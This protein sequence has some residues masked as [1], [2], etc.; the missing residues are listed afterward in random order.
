MESSNIDRLESGISHLLLTMDRSG[1]GILI[2]DQERTIIYANETFGRIF[3]FSPDE[4]V[5]RDV[6]EVMESELSPLFEEPESFRVRIEAVYRKARECREPELPLRGVGSRWIT[7]SSH[8]VSG[9]ALQGLRLD[10]F[11]EITGIKQAEETLLQ[12]E[13]RLK[14]LTT[15]CG[16]CTCTTGPDL[17][18][19]T[20]DETFCEMT[21]TRKETV[22]GK[23]IRELLPGMA[24]SEVGARLGE[25]S[26]AQPTAVVPSP[27]GVW[28]LCGTFFPDGSLSEVQWAWCG[29][30]EMSRAAGGAGTDAWPSC[31]SAL[32]ALCIDG[33]REIGDVLAGAAR[34]VLEAAP[35]CS[36][37]GIEAP[38]ISPA[39]AGHRKKK[40]T[41]T[42]IPI[43]PGRDGGKLRIRH[44]AEEA[45]PSGGDAFLRAVSGVIGVYLGEQ[46]ALEAA[47]QSEVTYQT[48]LETTGTAT[49]LLD[50]GGTIVRMNAEFERLFGYNA[51]DLRNGFMWTSCVD[52][53]DRQMVRHFHQL[54]R[55][56]AGDIP[57]SYECRTYAKDGTPRDMI[58]NVSLIPGTQY[59]IISL[60]DITEQNETEVELRESEHRYQLIAE[61]ATDVIF[62]L[63]PDLRFTYVSPSTE[64]LLGWPSAGLVDHPVTDCFAAG[65]G[66]VFSGAAC[67]ILTAADDGEPLSRVMELEAHRPNGSQVWVEVRINTLRAGDGS[68]VGVMGVIR[69]ISE[70]KHAEEREI[71]Y[72]RE[73]SF[74]SSAAMG[75]VELPPEEEIYR[76][77][78]DRLCSLL[79]GSLA[80]VSRYD[81][82]DTTLTVRAISGIDE[83]HSPRLYSLARSCRGM[84]VS[85]PADLIEDLGRGVVLPLEGRGK[86]ELLAGPVGTIVDTFAKGTGRKEYVMGIARGDELFGCVVVV[87]R[88]EVCLESVSTIETFAHLSSVALQRRRLEVELESTKS[89][90]QHILSSSPVAI[91]SA[92]PSTT[93]RGMGPITFVTENITGLIGFEPQEILFDSTFWSTYIHPADRPRVQGEEYS[94]LL[95]EGKRTFEYRIRHKDGK[96]RWVHSEVRVIRN[97]E[98][99][100]VELIGSAIDISE[101]KRIEEA[102]R[103][104]DSA[105]TSSINPIIITD[106]EGDLV[107]ANH[108]ALKQ[109]DYENIQ[110]VVGKPLDRFWTQKKQIA[111][112]LDRIDRN[113]GWMG[114]LIGKKKGG[115]R[116][117]ASVSANM[118]TDEENEPLCIMLS[119]ADI[120]ERIEIEEELAKYRTHLEELVLERTEKLTRANELLGLEIS[121]RKRA[122]EHVRALSSFRES[123]IE[124]AMMLLTV[125]DEEGDVSVWNKAAA[126]ITGFDRD[127]MVGKHIDRVWETLIPDTVSRDAITH[128][129]YERLNACGRIENMEVL[130]RAKNGETKVLLWNGRL[131]ENSGKRGLVALAED[132]TVRKQMEE[133][134]RA[135]EARYRGVVEDQTEWI[136]RFGSDLHLSFVN[137]A[138]C[139]SFSRSRDEILGSSVAALLPEGCEDL[140]P[141]LA[142]LFAGGRQSVTLDGTARNP[143]GDLRWHQWTLRAIFTPDGD[144]SEY[145][146]VGRDITEVKKAEEE[147]VRTEKLLSLSEL[148][149]GIAHDFNNILTS[150]MGNLNLARMKLSPDDFVYHRLTEAE[151]ATM[152]AG[153]ITRQLFSFSDRTEP[154]KDTLD[155]ADIIREA[156]NY[157]LRGSKS[158]CRLDLGPGPMP[159]DADPAQI[160]QVLQALIINADQAMSGGGEVTVGA[161]VVEVSGNDPVPLPIGS[162]VRITVKD[163]GVGIQKEHLGRIFDP[164][165]TTKKHGSGLGLAVA[166]PII[167]NHG[168]W[169]DVASETGAGTTFSLYL[170]SSAHNVR[171]EMKPEVIT[172]GRIGSILLM[173]DEAGIL[174]TTS[175]I[176]RHLG[177]TVTTAQDGKEAVTR[178]EEALKEGK[179][180]DGAILDL[181]VPGKMGGE[182]TFTRLRE[183]D[184]AVKVVVSSGYLNDPVVRNPKKFGLFGSIGK[185]YRID[186]LSRVLQE[187]LNA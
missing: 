130:I 71:Q 134:I 143:E 135:S 115:K 15:A 16:I 97:E 164:Y 67:E 173:D 157:A 107:F 57:K 24:A 116:F 109:W 38:G 94:A 100:A 151:A 51:N 12:N 88:D 58:V 117:H 62:T 30:R 56:G 123:V 5:G 17:A 163:E 183:L 50:N 132:I 91:F 8:V 32:A 60:V 98:G 139:H 7:Y 79:E 18:V 69:D 172:S 136:C 96:Y 127:E 175:D 25:L 108:S 43:P 48:L 54:R 21:G 64:R 84:T 153:E 124:N 40:D 114:E 181:T 137:E 101:R 23:N 39:E 45:V 133:E 82:L 19:V 140:L 120:T 148:A 178:F 66:D 118:V 104:M 121:E 161:E 2:S 156:A 174:E 122:E 166:L 27:G 119:F 160:L 165:F 144:V 52:E 33:T 75:F 86:S 59:S 95:E 110:K 63:D 76:Y 29:E 80:I 146:A 31:L 70:R 34:L 74:L 112:I 13:K 92:E 4:L 171:A 111:A 131:V 46:T 185:P 35:W 154:R 187:L 126:E 22:R 68:P 26:A 78:A 3:G 36:W 65:D 184:P 113:G 90:L 1:D 28:R 49:F 42:I 102:L 10:I 99:K 81:D 61:N 41:E 14:N 179:P 103:V 72:V 89:R 106:L 170:P 147:F 85:V 142:G 168:G 9:S 152:R 158:T 159:V 73:L 186:E 128:D 20:A 47:Q 53:E 44:A 150:I 180:F 125:I 93:G 176:L 37:I 141:P 6:M 11:R 87:L 77:I 149:G 145:Q 182:E 129:I 177:Y 169:M 55:S 105:I 138:C 83:D 155:V 162:Y 167:K